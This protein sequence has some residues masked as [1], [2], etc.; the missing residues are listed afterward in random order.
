MYTKTRVRSWEVSP[1]GE[2]RRREERERKKGEIAFM[3]LLEEEE[4]EEAAATCRIVLLPPPS[5]FSRC[6]NRREEKGDFVGFQLVGFQRRKMHLAQRERG[7]GGR[8]ILNG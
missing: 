5:P 6:I 4:E 8:G 1:A 3:H 2:R 7:K